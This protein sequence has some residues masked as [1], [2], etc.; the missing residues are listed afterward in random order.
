MI[1]RGKEPPGGGAG[2]G[3]TLHGLEPAFYD[4]D[5]PDGCNTTRPSNQLRGRFIMILRDI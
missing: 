3:C 4:D 2:P 1:L 5:G